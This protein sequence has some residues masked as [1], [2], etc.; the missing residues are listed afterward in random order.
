MTY[1]TEALGYGGETDVLQHKD[2]EQ[3]LDHSGSGKDAHEAGQ[4]PHAAREANG[5]GNQRGH[6]DDGQVID[7]DIAPCQV[8]QHRKHHSHIARDQCD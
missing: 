5:V 7:E 1:L 8:A 6:A 4:A 3:E 2:A